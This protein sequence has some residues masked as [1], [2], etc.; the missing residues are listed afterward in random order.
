M[1]AIVL[2]VADGTMCRLSG[3][4]WVA[5]WLHP[6]GTHLSFLVPGWWE[7][8]YTARLGPRVGSNSAG[9]EAAAVSSARERW[10]L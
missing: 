1:L 10:L 5:R 3:A 7:A 9:A 8:A 4:A 2:Y 6:G